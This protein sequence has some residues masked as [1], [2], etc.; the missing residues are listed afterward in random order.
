MQRLHRDEQ[1]GHVHGSDLAVAVDMLLRMV[2]VQV[3][4]GLAKCMRLKLSCSLR[5]VSALALS[6][7]SMS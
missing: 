4:S 6:S 7:M 1:C 2:H 5:E 3:I